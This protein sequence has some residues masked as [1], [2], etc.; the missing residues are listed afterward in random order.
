[1]ALDSVGMLLCMKVKLWPNQWF[2]IWQSIVTLT[3]SLLLP[4]KCE[5]DHIGLLKMVMIGLM[6]WQFALK[7]SEKFGNGG[8]GETHIWGQCLSIDQCCLA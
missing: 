6:N 8:N 4:V 1:M 3:G 7:P 2:L 5:S